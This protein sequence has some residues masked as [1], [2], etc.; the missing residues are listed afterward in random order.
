MPVAFLCMKYTKEFGTTKLC[1]H[2]IDC[3]SVVMFTLYCLVLVSWVEANSD[4]GD[5][6]FVIG[7]LREDNT[8]HPV[9]GFSYWYEHTKFYLGIDFLSKHVLK[10]HWH[11]TWCMDN[12]FSIGVQGDV[13][14]LHLKGSQALKA[15]SKLVH[16]VQWGAFLSIWTAMVFVSPLLR[17]VWCVFLRMGVLVFFAGF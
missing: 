6:S 7:R 8:V 12:R 2:F 10:M 15:V 13:I 16:L 11:S 5:F 1:D 9:C 4:F 14:R 3:F 17:F